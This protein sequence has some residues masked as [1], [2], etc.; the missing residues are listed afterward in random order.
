MQERQG[1]DLVVYFNV[2]LLY[3]KFSIVTG[4]IF[5]K[6]PLPY[7]GRGVEVED[8]GTKLIF[9]KNF[10]LS[11][12]F[13]FLVVSSSKAAAFLVERLFQQCK[14]DVRPVFV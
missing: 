11:P 6:V 7:L 14:L 9:R 1:R 3:I 8:L 4:N 10:S 5:T 12:H 2:I 13:A